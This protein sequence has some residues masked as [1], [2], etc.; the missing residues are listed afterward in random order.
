MILPIVVN[1][2]EN[3]KEIY[4]KYFLQSLAP[5][6]DRLELHTNF[7]DTSRFTEFGYET[8]SWHHCLKEKIKYLLHV[9]N[10]TSHEYIIFSD[11]DVQFLQPHKLDIF[12][13]YAKQ[14]QLDFMG[15][16]EDYSDDYNTG[17]FVVR[18]NENMK[19]FFSTIVYI[20]THDDSANDQTVFNKLI[21]AFPNLIKHEP[22]PGYY[23]FWATVCH[24]LCPIFHHAVATRNVNE[25]MQ[26]MDDVM[27]CFLS[28]RYWD[29]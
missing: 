4:I 18:V 17:F 28:I 12:I 13:K 22:I 14:K 27:R 26:Q 8:C 19:N 16:K 15:M 2:S 25:K 21:A 7:I 24:G 3:Y 10:H 29:T 20:M 6:R 5:I 23:Y 11:A 1:I 9:L